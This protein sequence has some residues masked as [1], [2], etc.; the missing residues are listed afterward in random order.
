MMDEFKDLGVCGET[1]GRLVQLSMGGQAQS[2]FLGIKHD[3]AEE[4]GT[5]HGFNRGYLSIDESK[6]VV[7][8]VRGGGM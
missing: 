5:C 8:F 6:M 3:P 7:I 2:V 4:L 1:D